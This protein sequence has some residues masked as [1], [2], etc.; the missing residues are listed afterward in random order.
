[1]SGKDLHKE[2]FDESTLVKLD[3][4][5][6]YVRAWIPVFLNLAVDRIQI[7]DFFAGP[8]K[9]IN[10]VSGSPLIALEEIMTALAQR[11]KNNPPIHL[12]FNEYIKAKYDDLKSLIDGTQLSGSVKVHLLNADFP[13]AFAKWGEIHSEE[14]SKHIKTADLLF[15]DQNGTKQ[16]TK[17]VF[18]RITST[19]RTDFL[20]FISSSYINRFKGQEQNRKGTPIEEADLINMTTKTSHRILC[21]AYKRWLP[22]GS[23]YYLAPFS[24][25]K[26]HGSNVYGLI[27]GSRHPAGIDKF[28]SICWQEDKLRGEANFDIDG[29]HI[30]PEQ[31]TFWDEINV[32]NKLQVFEMHLRELVLS[33]RLT[34]NVEVH[35]YA[36]SEACRG[37]HAKEVLDKLVRE[38]KLPKQRFSISYDSCG[39]RG[40]V[41]KP[42]LYNGDC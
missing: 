5:R 36:L 22:R 40:A 29:E 16:I 11:H 7:F 23:E 17:E 30:V 24:I 9:D 35:K 14:E 32:P 13:T 20:F 28:L 8:G 19:D 4:Y 18:S 31:R 41:P 33:K 10:N 39:L 34:T 15:L 2:A 26:D 3:L 1:M 12:Y 42:I 38:K 27:F 25:A 37:A 21:D 6:R